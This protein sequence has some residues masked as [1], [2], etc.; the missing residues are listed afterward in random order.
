MS[1]PHAFYFVSRD[2]IAMPSD[3]GLDP[4]AVARGNGRPI[5]VLGNDAIIKISSRDTGGAF[6]VFEAQTQPLAGRARQ[7][8]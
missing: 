5:H 1:P 8:P 4:F 3:A 2:S 6:T 7:P